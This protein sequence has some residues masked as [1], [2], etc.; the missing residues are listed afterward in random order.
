LTTDGF[1]RADLGF[2][3]A[4]DLFFVAV[5]DRVLPASLYELA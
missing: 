2:A 1:R 4:D 5:I 3:H